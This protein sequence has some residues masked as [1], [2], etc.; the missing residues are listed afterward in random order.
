MRVIA[1]HFY[2]GLKGLES[3]RK[4]VQAIRRPLRAEAQQLFQQHLQGL[5]L[6]ELRK[7]SS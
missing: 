2:T 1:L 5:S 7:L 4:D 3:F 6:H